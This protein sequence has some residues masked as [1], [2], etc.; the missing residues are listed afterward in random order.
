[1]TTSGKVVVV[2][3]HYKQ[4]ATLKGA[5][6]WVISE[7]EMVISGHDAWVTAYK[8]VPMNLTSFGGPTAGTLSTPPSRS[9]T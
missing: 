9:T 3:Q 2:D 4:V 5:D 7:H 6:G 1:M 8:T